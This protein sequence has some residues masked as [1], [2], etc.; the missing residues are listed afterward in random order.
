M[1]R[2]S[3]VAADGTRLHCESWGAGP[4]LLFVHG[5]SL[6]SQMWE[7]QVAAL[8]G[9]GLRCLTYD[10]RGHG[11]SDLPSSGYDADTLADDLAAV[12]EQLDLREVT[13]VGHSMGGGEIARC[14]ARHGRA[15]ARVTRAVLVSTA[16]PFLGCNPDRPVGITAQQ[17]DALAAALSRDRYGWFASGADGFFAQG[18]PGSSLSPALVEAAL[19]MCVST[20][21]PVQLA[22]LRTYTGTDY[23]DDLAGLDLPVLVVHGDADVSAPLELTGRASAALVPGARLEVYAGAPHGLYVTEQDRLSADLLAFARP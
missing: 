1:T 23:R 8:V 17:V 9:A 6:R 3:V 15:R 14:L 21:L 11:R 20:P 5:W 18:G 13:L 22:C 16:T 7:H 10:R 19:R 12:L 2:L 4:T